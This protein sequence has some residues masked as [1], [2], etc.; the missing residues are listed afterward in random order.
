MDKKVYSAGIVDHNSLAARPF[1]LRQFNLDF[2]AITFGGEAFFSMENEGISSKVTPISLIYVPAGQR[3][4]YDPTVD[5]QWKNYWILFD[6]NAA[7]QSFK[8]LMPTPGAT[9][10]CNVDKLSEYWEKLSLYMLDASDID[11]ERAFCMLHNILLELREQ[12]TSFTKEQP[13]SA[14]SE[15][16]TFLHNNLQNSE[17]NFIRLANKNGICPDSLRKR[18]KRETGIALHQYFIQLKINAAKSM[19]SNLSYNISDLADFLG[20]NDQYYFSRL[21]KNKTGLSPSKYRKSLISK[22]N[23]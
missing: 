12:S 8:Q 15:T 13:S 4:V 11:D 19:L 1:G 22:Q 3:H 18:F 17:L 23:E 6:G 9:S 7:R 10:I 2:L 5:S 20:F 14:I 16:I 21:F